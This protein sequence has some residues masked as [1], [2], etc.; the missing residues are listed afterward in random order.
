[1]IN[2]VN[3][4]WKNLLSTGNVF[5]E[6]D[7]NKYQSTLICGENGAGKTTLLDAITFVLYGKAF[8]NINV[9]QLVNSINAK[10]CV[11]E[12]RFS[13]NGSNYHVI[14]GLAPKIFSIEKDGILVDQVSSAKDYQ[15]ILEK[16]ILGMNFKT[17]CQV[18]I[19]GSNNYTPFMRLSPADRRS[20]VEN[21]LDIDVFTRMN[22]GL[23]SRVLEAK[24]DSKTID[25]T[26]A[27]LKLKIQYK[28]ELI[29]KIEEKSD[30]QIEAYRKQERAE[31]ET[32]DLAVKEK[33]SIREEIVN[34][35]LQV[36]DIQQKRDAVNSMSNIKKNL[37]TGIKKADDDSAFYR[38]NVDCPVCK[39][40][41][42]ED[43]RDS[44]VKTKEVR[45]TEL[46]EALD[47][48]DGMIEKAQT[49]LSD[50]SS[51][52]DQLQRLLNKS[53]KIDSSIDSSRRYIKQLIEHQEKTK[54]E[55]AAVNIEKEALVKFELE[56]DQADIEKKDV[57][58]RIH[59]MEVASV[60]LKDSG[61]KRKIIGKYV[62]ALNKIINQ[63]LASMDFFAQFTLDDNFNEII[64]SRFRDEF[65]YDNFSEGEKLR[66]DLSLLLA[67]RD[68][69]KMKNSANT[70][71]LILDEVLDSSLDSVGTE[72]VTKILQNV[73]EANNIFVISHK[74][75]QLLDK[76][77]NV[78]VF[79]KIKNFSK[80]C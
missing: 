74:A 19:L 13:V 36:A 67:W 26:M 68:I 28:K 44:L 30:T 47:K 2:F 34:L 76:F 24:D 57:I 61:I 52:A 48:I 1:M 49:E 45:K 64:K 9:A 6:V 3:L 38:D 60:L 80:L 29:V 40:V 56:S 11:V 42:D 69:S 14:R 51:N 62:P 46:H 55:V 23:K 17:F 65:S 73:G 79:K 4:K 21:L 54:R 20:I 77:Q 5:T 31:Q 10:D 66:I 41:I 75:D 43:F 53:L 16:N 18:V 58:E 78:L 37:L 15:Q 59:L 32:I 25:S 72:E 33:E 12:I 63:Y 22:D 8:R 7:L 70:N 71:L 27:Q 35:K 39:Q 50:L